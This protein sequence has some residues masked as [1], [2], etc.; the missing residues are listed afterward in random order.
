MQAEQ[1]TLHEVTISWSIKPSKFQVKTGFGKSD[2]VKLEEKQV[3]RS[4][5]IRFGQNN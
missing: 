5:R 4:G 3:G 2:P 1:K